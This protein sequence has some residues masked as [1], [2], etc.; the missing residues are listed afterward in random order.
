MTPS[1]IPANG[2]DFAYLEVGQGPLALCLHGFPD[3]A[4]SFVPLLEHLGAAG[5][6]A[7]APFMRGYLPSGLAPDGDYRVMTL[8]RDALSLI[9]A[10]GAQRKRPRVALR[11]SCP[12]RKSDPDIVIIH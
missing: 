4:W 7:V 12:C 10:L 1:V 2:V 5:Y 9:E 8:G 6:R 11:F 3:T